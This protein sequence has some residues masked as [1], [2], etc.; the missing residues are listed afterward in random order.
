MKVPAMLNTWSFKT[1]LRA[2]EFRKIG[3][4]TLR[5]PSRMFKGLGN[6]QSEPVGVFD[7]ELKIDGVL[8]QN[9]VYVTTY[10][11]SPKFKDAFG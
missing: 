4:L 5:P 7:T 10:T 8:Y 2:E 1:L 3:S 9:E 11:R 6:S